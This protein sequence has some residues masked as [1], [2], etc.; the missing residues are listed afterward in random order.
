MAMRPIAPRTPRVP[1]TV[2]GSTITALGGALLAGILMMASPAAAQDTS[3]GTTGAAQTSPG[4]DFAAEFNRRFR[5]DGDATGAQPERRPY[6][7]RYDDDDE[8]GEDGGRS[9]M[10]PA[11]RAE[12]DQDRDTMSGR[13]DDERGENR[14]AHRTLARPHGAADPAGG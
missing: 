8:R 9:D 1:P 14:E 11:P 7:P 4:E 12:R 2:A 10:G 5:D 13:G 6:D 3:P